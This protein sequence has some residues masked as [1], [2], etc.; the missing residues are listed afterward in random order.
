MKRHEAD[1]FLQGYI[2]AA[3][4]TT[5][6]EAPGGRDYVESGRAEE[7]WPSLPDWWI[8]EARKRC[9]DFVTMP[10][11][12]ELLA[13]AGDPWQNGSDLWYTSAGHGVG[14]WDR[15]YPDEVADPLTEAAH[16]MGEHYLMAEDFGCVTPE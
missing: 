8:E 7:L 15:G 1:P 11:V 5:D 3:L 9:A 4:F 16:K 13:K 2:N 12:A 10:G 14:Y 6:P